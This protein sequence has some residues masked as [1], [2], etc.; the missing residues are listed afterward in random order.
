MRALVS[1]SDKEGVVDFAKALR[2]LGWEVIATGG[3]MNAACRLVERMR[4]KKIHVNFLIELSELKGREAFEEGI[5][6]HSILT[7]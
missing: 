2:R 7:V 3:T 4:P 5:E 6:V 1:V